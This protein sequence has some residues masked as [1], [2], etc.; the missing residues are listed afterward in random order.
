[1][2]VALH[3]PNVE[4]YDWREHIL[5]FQ[6]EETGS[7]LYSWNKDEMGCVLVNLPWEIKN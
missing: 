4:L 7:G 6:I 2:D 5:T 1:M 3:Q